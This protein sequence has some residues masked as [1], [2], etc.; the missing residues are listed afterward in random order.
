LDRLN[1]A[2][3]ASLTISDSIELIDEFIRSSDSVDPEAEQTIRSYL[4]EELFRL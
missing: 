4:Q 3:T 2:S 1:E